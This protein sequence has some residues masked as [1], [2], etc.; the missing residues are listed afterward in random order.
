MRGKFNKSL[1]FGHFDVNSVRN[2]FE[3]LEILIK[4]K[5]DVFLISE[6]KHDLNSKFQVIGFFD[7]IEIILRW[8][9]LYIH[10]NIPLKKIESFQF[11]SS[12]KILTLE[13]NLGK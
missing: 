3:A 1:F 9:N 10:Q 6:C 8:V 5:F 11:T 2:K 12:I 4:D 7:K 13:I